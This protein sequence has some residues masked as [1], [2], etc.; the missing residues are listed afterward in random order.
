MIWQKK[1]KKSAFVD[2]M[3]PTGTILGFTSIFQVSARQLCEQLRINE[4]FQISAVKLH[5]NFY[6]C[7]LTLCV[8]EIQESVLL[9][10]EVFNESSWMVTAQFIRNSSGGSRYADGMEDFGQNPWEITERAQDKKGFICCHLLAG[11]QRKKNLGTYAME[12][13]NSC[14]L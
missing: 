12:L 11:Q 14:L 5:G 13:P 10:L 4:H 3:L 7:R 9:Q 6:L 2:S 8:W 1:K